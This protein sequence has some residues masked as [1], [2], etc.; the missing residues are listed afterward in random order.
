MEIRRARPSDAADCAALI[1]QSAEHFLPAVFGPG[2]GRALAGLSAAKTGLFSHAHTLI[3]EED[4]RTAGM[5]LGYP[6]AVKAREDPRTGLLLLTH[7]GAGM[8]LRLPVLLR[9]QGTVAAVDRA[10]WYVSNAAVHP[11]WRGRGVGSALLKAA[12]DEAG[13]QGC[14]SMALDVET[15]NAGA[16]RLYQRLGYGITG[17][18]RS[19]AVGSASFSFFRMEKALK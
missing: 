13:R 17:P 16:I 2:I 9:A 4:G 12:E 5:L 7:L 11:E 14:L 15:D 8:I 3:A 1:L 10:V 6:G 19:M 18:A